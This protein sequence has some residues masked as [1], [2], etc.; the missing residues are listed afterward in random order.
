MTNSRY[1][2]ALEDVY[3]HNRSAV[4]SAGLSCGSASLPTRIINGGKRVLYT[5][6]MTGMLLNN[7]APQA[8]ADLTVSA[9]ETSTGLTVG[10]DYDYDVVSNYGTTI[11]TIIYEGGIEEVYSGGVASGTIINNG[12]PVLPFSFTGIG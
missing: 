12:R 11:S 1:V 9:G 4:T 2:N 10:Y 3:C 6:A 7:M 5:A 8:W